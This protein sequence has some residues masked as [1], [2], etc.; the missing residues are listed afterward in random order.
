MDFLMSDVLTQ[1]Q[2]KNNMKGT[3][4]INVSTIRSKIKIEDEI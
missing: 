3:A 2:H 1:A 4:Q